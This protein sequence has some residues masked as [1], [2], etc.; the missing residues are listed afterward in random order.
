MGYKLNADQAL[1]CSRANCVFIR[2]F[3]WMQ[4]VLVSNWLEETGDRE[5]NGSA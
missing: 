4:I 5:R 3:C 1:R 2:T